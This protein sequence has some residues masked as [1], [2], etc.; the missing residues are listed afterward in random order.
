M[1]FIPAF[2]ELVLTLSVLLCVFS[3]WIIYQ[4]SLAMSKNNSLQKILSPQR[5]VAIHEVIDCCSDR[6]CLFCGNLPKKTH[7]VW[8]HTLSITCNICTHVVAVVPCIC[9]FFCAEFT[10]I[11][12]IP[13]IWNKTAMR[14][15]TYK[16]NQ[17]RFRGKGLTTRAHVDVETKQNNTSMA[18]FDCF[19]YNLYGY[20]AKFL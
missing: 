18:S 7:K 5:L 17:S 10:I 15:Q 12:A 3:L 13:Q 4:K 8:L 1:P 19:L 9:N 11:R 6:E 16:L 2:A 20:F 14:T